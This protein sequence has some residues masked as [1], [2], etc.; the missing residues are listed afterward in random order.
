M[1][2]KFLKTALI[3]LILSFSTASNAGL[4]IGNQEF[5]ELGVTTGMTVAQVEAMI[6]GDA[7]LS[8]YSLATDVDAAALY[9]IIPSSSQSVYGY[10]HLYPALHDKDILD[11]LDFFTEGTNGVDYGRSVTES[12]GTNGVEITFDYHS[13][14]HVNFRDALTGDFE[15]GSFK[16]M[17]LNGEHVGIRAG[18]EKY[19]LT[20][21]NT[22][23]GN[24]SEYDWYNMHSLYVRAA[25]V[26][27]PSTLAIFALGIMGLA[28]RRF[29]K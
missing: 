28:S 21:I 13:L 26:P 5:L 18:W 15:A 23:A 14:G 12:Q 27:E 25:A 16:I 20:N 3:S 19:D 1:S 17:S 9:S 10:Y 6:A 8:G 4:I 7:S 29:K 2:F 22:S 11:V 24:Y